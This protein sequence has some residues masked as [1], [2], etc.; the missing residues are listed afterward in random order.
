MTQRQGIAAAG[1]WIIDHVK[2]IDQFP[3]EEHLAIISE[4][5]LGTGGAPYN[6][7][8]G[9]AK[10]DPALSLEA[11]GVVGDD[12]DGRYILEHL[13]KLNI[14]SRA[15]R[16]TAESPTSYTDVMTVRGGGKR[17]FFHN[18]GANALL[19]QEHFNFEVTKA[20]I[21]HLGY[22]MLLNAMD[23]RDPEDPS[24]TCA[25]AV[26]EAARAAGMETAVDIVTD[27]SPRLHEVVRPALKHTDYF[28]TNELEAAA[29]AGRPI[30]DEVGKLLPE[31]F[32]A[33]A[34][35]LFSYGVH[36]AVVVHAPEG[37]FFKSKVGTGQ[38][39]PSL[40]VP[41]EFIKGTAGAGDAFCAGILYGIHAG[42]SPDQSLTLAV[43]NAAESLSHA[44]CTEGILPLEQ[45]MKLVDQFGYREQV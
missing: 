10:L 19:C 21:L 13:K 22:L 20:R 31:N 38:F 18:Y 17:T 43:A 42:W 12:A 26:L 11:I 2:I 6:V 7:L 8:V 1:N 33:I 27:L 29:V 9:L 35:V 45:T 32:D 23:S 3:K 39:K 4:E 28:I 40:R 36:K 16:T 5:V 37:G 44:T 34:D 14:D 41:Q 24:R 15:M 30:R 25:A